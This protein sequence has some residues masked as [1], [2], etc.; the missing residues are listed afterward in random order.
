MALAPTQTESMQSRPG[1]PSWNAPGKAILLGEHAVVYGQPALAMS[2]EFGLRV[3]R[4]NVT[5]KPGLTLHLPA[6]GL[7]ATSAP[8]TPFGNILKLLDE[9]LPGSPTGLRLKVAGRLPLGAGLGGSAALSVALVRAVGELRGI[10]LDASAVRRHAH[11]LEKIFHGSPSGLDDSLA[12]YGGLALFCRRSEILEALK[13]SWPGSEALSGT[14]LR[15]DAP[16]PPLLVGHTNV[17]R[18]TRVMVEKVRIFQEVTPSRAEALFGEIG[19][20]TLEGVEALRRH[21]WSKLGQAMNRNQEKLRELELSCNEIE[22]M[23]SLSL[24]HGALGAK[25]TGAGGGGC[26]LALTPETSIRAKIADAW[27][28]HGFGVFET[29]PEMDKETTP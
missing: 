15:L 18:D 5:E 7:S 20:I 26:V 25:L 3:V 13:A 29:E 12:A 22:T 27:K 11:E 14:L 6:I 4:W 23:I 1:K 16:R 9:S 8:E 10:A 21:D 19:R 17:P 24:E 28:N 2:L